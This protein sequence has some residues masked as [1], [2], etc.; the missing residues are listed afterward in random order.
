[1]DWEAKLLPSQIQLC[2][3]FLEKMNKA[4]YRTL[5]NLGSRHSL[6]RT[7]RRIS[8]WLDDTFRTAMD[9]ACLFD[10]VAS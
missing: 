8:T 9:E 3:A 2:P 10:H 5:D 4:K 7:G 1:M 6:A